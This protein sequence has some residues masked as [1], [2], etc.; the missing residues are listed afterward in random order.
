M[1]ESDTSRLRARPRGLHGAGDVSWGLAW[2]ALEWLERNAQPGWRTLETGS[3]SSTIVL[4]S[5]GAVHEAVTPDPAEETRIRATCAEFGISSDT[6]TFRIGPSHEVLPAPEQTPLDLVLIDGAHGFPYPVLDW[7]WVAPRLKVGGV[8]L[9]DDAYMPPVAAIVDALRRDPAWSVEGPV[10]YRTVILRKRGES[11]PHFDW[12]GRM[13]GGRMSF[14][15]LPP[16]ARVVAS[17]R[18]RFFSTRLGLGV[19]RVVRR[20]SGLRWRKTG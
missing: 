7:W 9:L 2:A 19:V 16:A 6:V 12:D 5:R 4:A 10:G 11:L 13:V 14:R 1:T 8:V 20:R 18:H 17:A 3:G 15:Y